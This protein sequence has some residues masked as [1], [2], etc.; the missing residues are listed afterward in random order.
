MHNWTKCTPKFN[1][2]AQALTL[3]QY[4]PRHR[5]SCCN[6]RMESILNTQ[7]SQN[8]EDGFF[9]PGIEGI[10]SLRHF[11][12]PNSISPGDAQFLSLSR[13]QPA[14]SFVIAQSVKKHNPMGWHV[15]MVT[16]VL[17]FDNLLLPY[18]YDM[19]NQ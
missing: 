10:S 2:C 8:P 5:F 17:A 16:P 6:R 18:A 12:V 11:P 13:Q 9:T 15:R 4:L 14:H 7:C 19:E 3:Y 1:C